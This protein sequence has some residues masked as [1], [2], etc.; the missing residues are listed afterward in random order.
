MTNSE[1]RTLR[2]TAKIITYGRMDTDTL[3]FTA[4]N[5]LAPAVL[6]LLDRLEYEAKPELENRVRN[7]EKKLKDAGLMAFRIA[8]ENRKIRDEMADLR[9]SELCSALYK[10]GSHETD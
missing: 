10:G 7:L 6:E 1:L 4:R 9:T 8:E 5:M 2:E 3:A